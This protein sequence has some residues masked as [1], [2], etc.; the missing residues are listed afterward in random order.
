MNSI[1]WLA[2]YVPY[3]KVNHAGGKNLNGYIDYFNK[4]G[5]YNITFIGLGYEWERE[6][7]SLESQGIKTYI[8]YRDNS[9]LDYVAR[10]IVSSFSLLNYKSKYYHLLLLY[11]RIQ[12]QSR[13]KKYKENGGSPDIIILQWTAMG[14]LLPWIKELFPNA[15]YVIIEED[16]SYLGFERKYEATKKESNKGKLK[17]IKYQYEHLKQ[18]ELSV[19]RKSDITVT[20]N[21]KDK[22][23]LISD[24]INENKVFASAS[25]IDNYSDV[26]R[27]PDGHTVLFYGSMERS[28]NY[29]A[30]IW[31]IEKVMPLLPQNIVF[32]VVGSRPSEKLLRNAEEYNKVNEIVDEIPMILE[33][34]Y[35]KKT[36]RVRIEGF[37]Q[38]IRPF[39][40]KTTC[41]VAPLLLGAGIKIKVLEAMSAGV[42][43]ITNDIGVEGIYA[44]N[45]IEYIHCMEPE[46]YALEIKKLIDDSQN[47]YDIGD[48]ARLLVKNEFDA[49]KKAL[50]LVNILNKL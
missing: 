17:K 49:E 41:M 43:V 24:G 8:Y 7:V 14:L 3:Q 42:P 5:K 48:N 23:L 32:E 38:D 40:E 26:E 11:E 21:R 12:L 4:S 33:N 6:Y 1:L 19:I 44:H 50:D 31:F 22:K 37:V 29:E 18:D 20:M 30:A 45:E 35:I 27:K 47:C 16:V 36:D 46:E 13:V 2:P 39:L 10:R 28:E 34:K 25:F 15:K 9:K